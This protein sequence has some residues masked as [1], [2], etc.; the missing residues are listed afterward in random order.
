MSTVAVV[1]LGTMGSR[2]ARR[3]LEQGCD[4]IVW[5]RTSARAAALEALGAATAASP[6]EAAARAEAVLTMVSDAAALRSVTE[7]ASGVIAGGGK[8][9]TIVQ[10]STVGLPGLSR[11]AGLL[12]EGIDVLDAPVLGSVAEAERGSLTIFVGG[13]RTQFERWCPLL[14]LLGSP[15]HVG[16]FGAG[17]A[18][19]L[20]ANSTLFGVLG[21]L[22]EALALADGLG[23]SRE[24]A[25]EVLA[26]TPL[27]AQAERRRGSIESGDYP[28]R[29]TL[30]LARKDAGLI[31]DAGARTH[32][33]LPL[34]VAAQGW[35]ADAERAGRG[36][37]DYSA[38]LAEILSR[39]ERSHLGSEEM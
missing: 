25:Y 39:R 12:P 3:L 2:I 34:Q 20:V 27:A 24:A 31:L 10:M 32:T 30:S 16:R 13:Q 7:D 35:L 17:T 33:D 6:A 18:A 28:P 14:S 1:G 11:L 8:S 19:K 9:L 26:P 15:V 29:F 21:V 37:A 5:N 22:G 38:V 23:L 4:V 36:G